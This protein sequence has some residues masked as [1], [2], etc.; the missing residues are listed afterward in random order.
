[1]PS[2]RYRKSRFPKE[3][4]VLRQSACGD[5][6]RSRRGGGEAVEVADGEGAV[7]VCV[8]AL[9]SRLAGMSGESDMHASLYLRTGRRK[10]AKLELAPVQAN[11]W[12]GLPAKEKGPGLQVALFRLA[13]GTHRCSTQTR[14]QSLWRVI[15]PQ[16]CPRM[17]GC[18]GLARTRT[19][20][21]QLGL[22]GLPRVTKIQ[23]QM[24]DLKET[25]NG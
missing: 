1:M 23:A 14:S 16:C 3:L 19:S 25:R 17:I 12:H 18:I 10:R 24:K 22:C 15:L 5:V 11:G 20:A 21:W 4:N 13:V 2:H 8:A 9:D 6:L 7:A